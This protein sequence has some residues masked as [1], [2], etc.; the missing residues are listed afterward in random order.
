MMDL[1]LSAPGKD[2]IDCSESRSDKAYKDDR[3]N[4]TTATGH[5]IRLPEE[6]YLITEVLTDAEIDEIFY[7]DAEPREAW[8]NEH[9]PD[10]QSPMNQNEFD[11]L[12][13]FLWQYDIEDHRYINTK[14]AIISGNRQNIIDH[15]MLFRDSKAGSGD[16]KMLSR[17][18]R[19]VALFNS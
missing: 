8:L 10:W 15:L 17:R 4:W 3:G 18:Q 16:N 19:E 14:N 13:D 1:E 5:L 9:C 2:F 11:A 6:E 12:M 7:K